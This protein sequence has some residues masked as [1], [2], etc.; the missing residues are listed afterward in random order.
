MRDEV[1]WG[2]WIAVACSLTG[3]LA[4]WT[5]FTGG[6]EWDWANYV[7]PLLIAA[8]GLIAIWSAFKVRRV[9]EIVLA[10]ITCIPLA[11]YVALVASLMYLLAGDTS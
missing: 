8:G 7:G 11:V 1:A 6:Q 4:V 10:I 3:I 9:P 2:S 5:G